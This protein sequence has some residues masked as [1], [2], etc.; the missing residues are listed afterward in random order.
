VIKVVVDASVAIK[1]VIQE[2]GTHDAVT[3]LGL[4]AAA[5]PDFLMVE[6]ANILWKMVR[7]N[8]L[9]KREA[10]LAAKILTTAE[11]ELV[12][13]RSLLEPAAAIAIE[14]DH[15]AYDCMYLA[16]AEA[17]LWKYVTANERLVRKVHQPHRARLRDVVVPLS[18]ALYKLGLTKREPDN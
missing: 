12:H 13:T 16:L 17:N 11:V 3:L 18:G 2:E 8:Q 10:L 6:C 14:L 1:W 9:S 15:P 7:R 5:A 4:I